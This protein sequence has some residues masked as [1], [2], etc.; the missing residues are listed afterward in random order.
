MVNPGKRGTTMNHL[1]A[2][3]LLLVLVPQNHKLPDASHQLPEQI[4]E[5]T[6]VI[7][8]GTY[9]EGRSPC[10]FMP[11]GNRVWAQES[12][13][14]V[15]TVYRGE[16]GGKSIYLNSRVSPKIDDTSVYLELGRNSLVL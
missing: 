5:K 10:I 12:W 4:R 3:V 9:R 15:K 2:M 14:I 16:V 8:T 11:D 13:F 7:F 6:T 1:F